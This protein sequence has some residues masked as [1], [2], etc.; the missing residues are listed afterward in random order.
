MLLQADPAALAEEAKLDGCYVMKTDLTPSEAAKETVHASYKSLA[1]VEAAFR[2]SKT[3][4]LEM[5][6]VHVRKESNTRGHLLVVMLAYLLMVEL[7][8]R[9]AKLDCTVSEGL[10]RLNTYCAIEVAGVIRVLLE[11]RADVKE[12]LAAARIKLPGPLEKLA[13]PAKVATRKT[14][15]KNRP[16]RSQSA[17]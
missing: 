1:S 4:E 6:P 14:L 8:K 16:K 2:R 17:I 5:R 15:P 13:R 9:W 10:D 11:P 12:L 3:V 7:G